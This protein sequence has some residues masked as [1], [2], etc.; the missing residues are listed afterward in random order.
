MTYTREQVVDVAK[1]MVGVPFR[2]QGRSRETGVDCVGL[3]AVILSELGDEPHEF[4]EY[5]TRP[6]P[7]D[8]LRHASIGMI[9]IPEH[10]AKPGDVLLFWLVR[11]KETHEP[12]PQHFAVLTD[13]N[14]IIHAMRRHGE[15]A[16]HGITDYWIR[17]RHAAYRFRGLIDNGVAP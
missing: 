2:H 14:T 12:M 3:L 13:R 8:L 6:D 15:V 9:P 10:E 16:E 4:R 11:N 1:S 17:H 7:D 5:G